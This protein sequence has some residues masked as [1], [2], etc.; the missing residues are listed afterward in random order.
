M[1]P[2]L[3]LRNLSMTY[4]TGRAALSDVSL[5]VGKSERIAV[6][7]RSGAGKS[8]MLR[9]MNR[10]L[11]PTGGEIVLSGSPITRVHG[12]KL[13]D[14]RTRVGMIF[15]QFNLV[16]R[17]TV[18]ENVLVGW[19]GAQRGITTVPALWRQFPA[20]ARETAMA[21]LEEVQIADLAHQRADQ[22][23][24]GQ[25]QRVAIARVL[26]QRPAAILADEP[27]SSLDPRSSEIVLSTLDRIN[28]THG[29]P[30]VVNLHDV[31]IA[32][33]HADRVVGLRDG[34]LVLDT[35]ASALSDA[36]LAKLYGDGTAA[37][38][39]PAIASET[40]RALMEQHA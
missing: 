39:R 34:R 7:G 27:V 14:V 38:R 22:L 37:P 5:S 12:R 11:V 3:E 6:I 4:P 16:G 23:S 35:P 24:G 9:L 19:L 29:V 8:T 28:S 36:Q 32:R 10:L 1:T 21:C 30:V 15:Q 18:L 26:A 31:E 20:R 2:V 17:L 33:R 13:R 40:R 25:A